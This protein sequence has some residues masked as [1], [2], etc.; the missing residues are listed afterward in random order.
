ML[1]YIQSGFHKG[2]DS[3]W[4]HPSMLRQMCHQCLGPDT[5]CKFQAMRSKLSQTWPSSNIYL[6]IS[7]TTESQ[8]NWLRCRSVSCFGLSHIHR[9]SAVPHRSWRLLYNHWLLSDSFVE[10]S[11]LMKGMVKTH[12]SLF[13]FVLSCF[14]HANVMPLLFL[15]LLQTGWR[16]ITKDLW[17]WLSQQFCRVQNATIQ[18]ISP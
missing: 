7:T 2:S 6:R 14:S 18:N 1:L 4:S 12:S 10:V 11:F 17:P 16:N 8:I 3:Q 13:R 15:W 9:G 5:K